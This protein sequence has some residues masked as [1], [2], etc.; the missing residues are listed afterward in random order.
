MGGR[1]ERRHVHR[2]RSPE[3]VHVRREREVEGFE[4]FDVGWDEKRG[5]GRTVVRHGMVGWS[6]GGGGRRGERKSSR[7]RDWIENEKI[8]MRYTTDD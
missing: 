4:G 6:L 8:R 2:V 7:R 5:S 3:R 1:R